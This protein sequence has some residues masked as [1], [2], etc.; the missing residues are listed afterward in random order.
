MGQNPVAKL[1]KILFCC[2]DVIMII[3][4]DLIKFLTG[5]PVY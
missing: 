5:A 4:T 2:H 1:D 3:T